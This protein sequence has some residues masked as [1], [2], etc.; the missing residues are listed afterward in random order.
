M[1]FGKDSLLERRAGLPLT[2][3]GLP[4]ITGVSTSALLPLHFPKQNLTMM[5][6]CAAPHAPAVQS[7]MKCT[8]SSLAVLLAPVLPGLDLPTYSRK[9]VQRVYAGRQNGEHVEEEGFIYRREKESIM[10][11]G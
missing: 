9:V 2:A 5:P 7:I 3:I 10:I 11:L 1:R 4:F 8:P 6:T